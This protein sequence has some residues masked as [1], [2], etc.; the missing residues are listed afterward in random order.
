MIMQIKAMLHC[1]K[2]EKWRLKNPSQAINETTTKAPHER[3]QK[4]FFKQPKPA[5]QSEQPQ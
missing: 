1:N 3:K 4:R 2:S 5:L